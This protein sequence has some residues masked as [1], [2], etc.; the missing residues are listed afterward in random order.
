MR[1]LALVVALALVAPLLGAWWLRRAGALELAREVD[2]LHALGVTFEFPRSRATS[3]ESPIDPG[4][5]WPTATAAEHASHPSAGLPGPFGALSRVALVASVARGSND[6]IPLPA[7]DPLYVSEP[8][9]ALFDDSHRDVNDFWRVVRDVLREPTT[10]TQWQEAARC[11][12]RAVAHASEE[13]LSRAHASCDVRAPL[14]AAWFEPTPPPHPRSLPPA[15]LGAEAAAGIL[16]AEARALALGG[17]A[18]ECVRAMERAL[19]AARLGEGFGTFAALRS[20]DDALAD[21]LEALCECAS[22]LPPDTDW[23]SWSRALDALDPA[24]RARVACDGEFALTRMIYARLADGGECGI[25]SVDQRDG[26]SVLWTACMLDSDQAALLACLR[27]RRAQCDVDPSANLAAAVVLPERPTWALVANPRSSEW[28][29]AQ[30]PWAE[31]EA[32]R[33]IAR[34]VLSA[35]RSGA[36]AARLACERELDPY[37]G[38]PLRS[39]TDAHS[40]FVVW[41]VGPDRTDDRGTRMAMPGLG[42]GDFVAK[43]VLP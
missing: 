5:W 37:T 14:A 36:D 25:A 22:L 12:W 8:C 7:G 41:S 20:S 6:E 42:A 3:S 1:W 31:L 11:A 27:A 17:A 23:S 29:W 2:A 13:R 21:T 19:C 16:R 33:R 32:R 26:V 10:Q 40:V 39:R 24:Q 9:V 43:V 4:T 28:D 18:A 35:R 15:L 30:H 38:S 34:V